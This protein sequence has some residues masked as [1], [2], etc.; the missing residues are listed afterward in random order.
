M[1]LR[2]GPLN[3]QGIFVSIVIWH[4]P[5]DPKPQMGIEGL[6]PLIAPSYLCP[7]LF[8]MGDTYR[9]LKKLFPDTFPA[10]LGID[11]SGNNVS[12][13]SEDDVT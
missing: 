10:T 12:L 13:F 11:G 6:C 7:H 9:L 5:C 2:G 1:K 3:D 4:H 8:E